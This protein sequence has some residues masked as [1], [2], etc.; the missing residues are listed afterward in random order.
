MAMTRTTRWDGTVVDAWIYPRAAVGN[1]PSLPEPS[2]K[3]FVASAAR[4]G[5]VR[6]VCPDL[7]DQRQ[8]AK[9][10][11]SAVE[12]LAKRGAVSIGLSLERL[13]EAKAR[14]FY[15]GARQGAYRFDRYRKAET[16]NPTL[17]VRPG[18]IGEEVLDR[19][20]TIADA[21][22]RARDWVNTAPNDKPPETMA[23]MFREG[24]PQSVRYEI[25]VGDELHAMGAGGMSAVGN[26]SAVHGRGPAVQIGRYEGA[27]EG[28]PW[29]ALVGKGI[30]F[31]SGG[32]TLKPGE[33]MFRM[34]GD[35]AGAAAAMAALQAIAVLRLKVNVLAVAAI[36]ENIVGGAGYRP[37]D[38]LRMLDGSTVEIISTD[39]EGRLVLADGVTI[40]RQRGA[41]AVVDIATLTGAN[42]VALG[43]IRAG[44]V[45]N[46]RALAELVKEA[47]ED[48][49]EL[50]WEMPADA[51]YRELLKSP[52]ADIKNSGGRPGGVITGGLFVGH[53]AE[54]VPWAHID[55][56]G[57]AFDGNA[58]RAN[59]F[60]VALLVAVAERWAELGQ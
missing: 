34:K 16:A 39:A 9:L 3:D 41:A 13:S 15:L 2:G 36:A 11:A 6:V 52:V 27:G 20:A 31:D 51:P 26:A 23:A 21:Q 24:A 37:G 53:F 44:V 32:L 59:G 57:M 45:A 17:H 49:G 38:V 14:A 22:D 30:T 29:L 46:D 4:G 25:L 58:G 60:G 56:A 40:A 12:Y 5:P 8:S 50:T 33:G 54:G 19:F 48:A 43:A 10:C 7:E 42:V 1:D 55:I 35:M 18:E 28:Q 47:G